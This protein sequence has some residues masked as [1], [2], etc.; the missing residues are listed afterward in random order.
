MPTT[1][2]DV[3]VLLL[4]HYCLP[5]LPRTIESVMAQ[6]FD[7]RRIRLVAVDNNSSDGTYEALLKHAGDSPLAVYRIN[8]TLPPPRLLRKALMF[9]DFI[10]YRYI[11]ILT[12]GDTLYPD[13]LEKCC[14][15]MD[16][17]AD[18]ED[19]LLLCETDLRLN[20]K[21]IVRQAPVFS[22]DCI[23]MKREHYTQFFLHGTGHK[24]QA[25]YHKKAMLRVLPDLVFCTDYTDW[26]KKAIYAFS[27]ECVYVREP[28]ACTS[29]AGCEDLLQDLILRLFL[30]KRAELVLGAV[31]ATD[32]FKYLDKGTTDG[33]IY[34][35]LARFALAYA[36][37]ALANA[38]TRTAEDILTFAEM[39][40]DD[41][42][43]TEYYAALKSSVD[44]G[45]PLQS[46]ERF[47]MAEKTAA[48]PRG[49]RII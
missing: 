29:P 19:K 12:P 30:V 23:L 17:Y 3:V 18:S 24:V 43:K 45:M 2:Y 15:L 9:L 31:Y 47:V 21:G 41:I 8:E 14:A 4:T 33:R 48:P 36:S 39:I 40:H 44:L 38:Q 5:V 35:N 13:Y 16:R 10:E 20:G 26:F 6:S 42:T 22:N 1:D 49:A 28:L 25:L 34:E 11:T 27:A 7:G 46:P 32:S 37:D